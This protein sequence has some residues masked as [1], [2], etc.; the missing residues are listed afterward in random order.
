ME[1][2]PPSQTEDSL[3]SNHRR[4]K[5]GYPWEFAHINTNYYRPRVPPPT[6]PLAVQRPTQTLITDFFAPVTQEEYH[7][8]I[9]CEA[10]KD[11]LKRTATRM[12]Q[13]TS[14]PRVPKERAIQHRA[15]E[16]AKGQR[17]PVTGKRIRRGTT[18]VDAALEDVQ[19]AVEDF[20]FVDPSEDMH[21]AVSS[22]EISHVNTKYYQDS[23]FQHP[24]LAAENYSPQTGYRLGAGAEKNPDRDWTIADYLAHA[25]SL[26]AAMEGTEGSET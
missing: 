19:S 22:M 6:R 14:H 1:G 17:D 15:S 3:S 11:D 20:V 16:M 25:G 12:P 10:H 7:A 21:M 2:I 4:V 8:S 5:S 9:T 26:E 24:P 18:A 13:M 23:G